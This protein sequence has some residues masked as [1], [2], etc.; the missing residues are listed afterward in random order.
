MSSP[1]SSVRAALGRLV[2]DVIR[3]RYA[4]KFAVVLLAIALV[5]VAAGA[6]IHFDTKSLVETQTQEEIRGIAESQAKSVADWTAAKES[7]VAFLAEA[8]GERPLTTSAADHERWLEQKLIELPGDVRSLH[9]VD[10]DAGFVVASTTDGMTGKSLDS[11]DAPWAGRADEFGTAGSAATSAPY[12]TGGE[13]VVA[14]VAPVSETGG[15]VVLTASIEARSHEFTSPFATG[16]VKVVSS[17]GTILLDNRKSS[18]LEQYTAL[19][20]SGVAAIDEGL[21]GHSGYDVVSA[22]TGMERGEYAMAYAPI[23]GTDWVLTYHVPA[24]RAFALQSQV[25]RNVALLLAFAVGALFLVGATMGRGTAR[26][27]AVVARSADEIAAGEVDADVPSTTRIDEVGRLYDSFAAVQSYLTTVAGQA[28]ALADK[29]FDDPVLDESVPGSFGAAMGRTHDDLE[30]LISELESKAEAFS[31]VMASAADGD[32]TNRMSEDADN[33][34]MNEMAR[35]YNE[36]ADALEATIAE[37]ASFAETVAAASEEVTASAQE[38]ER[39]SRQVSESSQAMADGAHE[40]QER[41]HQTT[42]ETSNLSAT[43]EEVASSAS[44]LEGTATHTL[45]ASEDGRSAAT[46]AI[47]TIEQVESQTEQTAERI[48]EL[49]ADMEEIGDIVE[50]I[51]DIAEQTNILALNANIEAARAGEAGEGFS[52]V[53]NEVKELAGETKASAEEIA[54]T[55]DGVQS[56]TEASVSEM[57]ETRDAVES[58]VEAV[59]DAHESLDV[60]VEN[61]RE[62]NQGVDEIS[63]TTDEQAASTEEV[64][65]MMD[66]AAD[67][68]E[69][70]AKRA[71]SVAAATEEQTASLGEV[72]SG[73]DRLASQSE[74]LMSL[75]SEFTVDTDRTMVVDTDT[76]DSARFETDETN[77]S[78]PRVVDTP[79]TDGGADVESDDS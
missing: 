54:D 46:N 55:I 35:S 51:T 70:T 6:F 45:E 18:L 77:E 38:I 69:E 61:V 12:D 36:M 15:F 44:E 60:I 39:A 21:A 66:R 8:L 34:A 17:D 57:R 64:A 52:V 23:T 68:S 11:L 65:S 9:Y 32:L 1:L 13:P 2:P 33:E 75:V 74:R 37:V 48:E 62:T 19:D 47:D 40:Q 59:E 25:T 31:S 72:S 22:R 42:S 14:F 4:A 3:R 56:K 76:A 78:A 67:I 27:L 58:G 10:A 26:S 71:E 50:L 30:A 43:I 20:G 28:E 53:A 7:S 79:A 29:E 49:E 24:D 63:R 5:M 41:I 73:A 16:D